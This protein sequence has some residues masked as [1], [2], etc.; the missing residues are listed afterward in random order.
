MTT[1]TQS[2][3]DAPFDHATN[4]P[5]TPTGFDV[6]VVEKLQ[7]DDV[8]RTVWWANRAC[9]AICTEDATAFLRRVPESRVTVELDYHYRSDDGDR[10]HFAFL[11]T[12]K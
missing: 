10:E 11:V 8:F 9:T 7:G 6:S 4:G 12:T 2:Q 3:T 1:Q 5:E